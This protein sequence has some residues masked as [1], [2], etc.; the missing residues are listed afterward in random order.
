MSTG[1]DNV[2]L[3]IGVSGL[4]ICVLGLIQ[5]RIGRQAGG[6]LRRHFVAFFAV[7]SAYVAC[8]LGSQFA[9]EQSGA[10][11]AMANRLSIFF[12]SLFS[13]VLMLFLTGFLFFSCGEKDL[14]NK[15]AYRISFV[16]WCAYFALLVFT[17]FTTAIYT[18]TPDNIYHRGPL[19]PVLLIPPVLMMLVNLIVLWRKRKKLSQ[20]QRFAFLVYFAVPMVSMLIQMLFYGVF[21]IVLGTSIAALFMFTFLLMD[22]TEN[23]YRQ[24]AENEKL[25]VDI[26]VAQIKPHFIYNCLT[27]IRSYLDEPEKAEE[28]LNHFAGFLRGSIDVLEETGLIPA[29]REIATIENYLYL[30]KERFG[31]KL[32][33]ETQIEDRDFF[34][35]AFA[36]QTLVENAVNHGVRGNKSGRGTVRI[37]SFQTEK[38]HVIEVEDDGTGYFAGE[39]N[40]A[41][42][43]P[44]ENPNASTDNRPH[45]GLSNL[46]KRLALMCDGTLE[47]ESTFG[48][49]TLARVRIPKTASA[50][51]TRF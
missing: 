30:E 12:E 34:L 7:L 42:S 39:G 1:N 6:G 5:A 11:W 32:Q 49:G 23:Y 37:R 19:Y 25:K 47:I 29:E 22:Q 16:L 13:S 26:L 20:K 31:K 35:P 9:A 48:K 15:A 21:V 41:L 18:V 27:A 3:I 38:E 2:N 50:N 45:I 8:N 33:V 46:R 36:V 43:N 17:Q 40:T 51:M 10:A 4:V 28:V 14:K 24:E 44:N